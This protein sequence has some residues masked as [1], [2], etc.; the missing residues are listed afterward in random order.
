LLHQVTLLAPWA[1]PLAWRP[2]MSVGTQ[3]QPPVEALYSEETERLELKQ[4]QTDPS[5]GQRL[6]SA[7]FAG[8]CFSV[9]VSQRR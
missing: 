1:G 2:P 3:E 9:R 8:E 7:D 4:Q 6:S 5:V